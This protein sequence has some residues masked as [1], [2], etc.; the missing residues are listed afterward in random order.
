MWPQI[1][2]LCYA[3]L[4]YNNVLV[5]SLELFYAFFFLNVKNLFFLINIKSSQ[6]DITIRLAKYV[7]LINI[8]IYNM[9]CEI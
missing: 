5:V 1:L 6:A 4:H 3:R 8:Y 9:A 7:P 2:Q